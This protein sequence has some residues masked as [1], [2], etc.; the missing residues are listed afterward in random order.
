MTYLI[1]LRV[2][3]GIK[4]IIFFLL[5][6][7]LILFFSKV[8]HFLSKVKTTLKPPRDV[9]FLKKYIEAF[10]KSSIK[11][12][13]QFKDKTAIQVTSL[14][15]IWNNEWGQNDY[16]RNNFG[17]YAKIKQVGN[18]SML[19]QIDNFEILEKKYTLEIEYKI[20]RTFTSWFLPGERVGATRV[21]DGKGNVGWVG[22]TLEDWQRNF[23]LISKRDMMKF[24]I[25]ETIYCT[26]KL[27]WFGQKSDS[28]Y[29]IIIQKMSFI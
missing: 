4:I 22:G 24:K 15:N 10:H 14:Q 28:N 29:L 19:L 21:S 9:V 23:R 5:L 17:F 3:I 2:D 13:E 1:L 27:T 26:G 16:R 12:N 25:G 11:L 7:L 20:T 6:L 18:D 8:L